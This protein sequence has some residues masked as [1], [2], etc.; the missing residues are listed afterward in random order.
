M[1][2]ACFC[3]AQFLSSI[4]LGYL[5]DTYGRK[6]MLQHVAKTPILILSSKLRQAHLV[7]SVMQPIVIMSNISSLISVLGF[8]SSTTYLSALLTRMSGGLCNFTF[9]YVILHVLFS[10]ELSDAFWDYCVQC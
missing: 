2:A 3:A 6:V 8:G 4:P 10:I 5:S 1:Q 7:S 9:G